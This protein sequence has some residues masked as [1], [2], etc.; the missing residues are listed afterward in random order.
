[1]RGRVR[2]R[3][4]SGPSGLRRACRTCCGRR[5]TTRRGLARASGRDVRDGPASGRGRA[6]PRHDCGGARGLRPAPIAVGETRGGR[7]DFRYLL[8]LEALSMVIMDVPGAAASRKPGSRPCRRQARR[9]FHALHGGRGFCHDCTA[10]GAHVTRNCAE[11]RGCWGAPAC[12]G[13]HRCTACRA[14]AGH[15][16]HDH[17][18]E[19]RGPRHETPSRSARA[20][21]CHDRRSTAK[22]V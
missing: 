9:A 15:E 4:R 22:D 8:E 5:S 13:Y 18:A 6:H 11:T 14:A 17:R 20:R 16:R 10:A 19:G 21:G 3:K 2:S 7:A 1:M 12:C